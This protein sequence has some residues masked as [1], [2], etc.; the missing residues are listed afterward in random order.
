MS[1]A[2]EPV[3]WA[4]A[5]HDGDYAL[6]L[7][8]DE[9][10][11][12]REVDRRT[13]VGLRSD[14]VVVPLYRHPPCQD[15]SQKNCTLTAEEREAIAFGIACVTTDKHAATLRKLLERLHT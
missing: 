8:F 6:R 7:C 2:Q 15:L 11:A 12:Q 5:A 10:T 4:V 3:A 9:P 1:D 13:A 14:Y